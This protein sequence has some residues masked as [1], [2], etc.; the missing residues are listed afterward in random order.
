LSS[1]HVDPIEKK[2]LFHFHPGSSV[3]SIGGWGCNFKCSFCQNWSISQQVREGRTVI[4]PEEVVNEAIISGATGI[5]YTYNEPLINIEYIMDCASLAAK[6]NL[7]NIVVT[8]GFIQPGPAKEI[9]PFIDALNIDIKSMDDS[10]YRQQCNGRLSPVLDFVKQ[11]AAC[12]KHVELTNLIIPGLNDRKSLLKDLAL[13]ISE[14]S[15][16]H[17]PLHLSAYHPDHKL[18]IPATPHLILDEAYDICREYLDY[19]YI[20]N[21]MRDDGRGEDTICPSCG[22][23]LIQ[24]SGF[25]SRMKGI[26]GKKCTECG[27]TTDIIT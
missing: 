14:E 12:R 7:L 3:F 5:A 8:N 18:T 24:R 23:V 25:T 20:G 22:N 27:R 9:L 17:T 4:P 6:N 21:V 16:R 13:W 10:F 26:T 19:V 1:V 11:C 2:P 15:G